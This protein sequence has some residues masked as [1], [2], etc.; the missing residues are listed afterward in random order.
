LPQIA[1][2]DTEGDRYLLILEFAGVPFLWVS[3]SFY[4]QI[5][6]SNAEALWV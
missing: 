6:Q 5:A 3:I 2:I 4:P 1:L